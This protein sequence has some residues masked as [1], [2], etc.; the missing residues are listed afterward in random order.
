MHFNGFFPVDITFSP[1]L[2]A[3]TS[4]FCNG[5][6]LIGDTNCDQVC[7]D[8]KTPCLD[9]LKHSI[10]SISLNKL[11]KTQLVQPI[12]PNQSSTLIDHFETNMPERITNC[13]FLL[14]GFSDH[15]M[16]LGLCKISGNLKERA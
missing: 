10:R 13:A 6:V 7:D 15:D 5:L 12:G 16:V 8:T 11:S 9:Y 1:F 2:L 3:I 14:V 4:A